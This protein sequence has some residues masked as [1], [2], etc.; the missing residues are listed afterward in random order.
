MD[1]RILR[2]GELNRYVNGLLQ[3]D[4]LLRSLRIRGEIS[5]FKAYPSGHWYFTLK[6]ESSAVSCVMWR[7]NAQRMSFR[8]KNGDRVILHGCARLYEVTGGFQLQADSMRLDG[9]GDLYQQF[10]QLK[11]RLRAEGLFDQARKRPLPARPRRIA[12]ITSAAGAVLHDIRHVSAARDPGIPLVLLPVP[13]QGAG[14]GREL[15]EA[16][17]LAPSLPLVDV[18]IIGRGGGSMEDLWCFNDEELARA[19]AACPVPV[20]SA[21]GHETDFT[22]CDFVSDVR[23]ATPSNAA[24]LA[25]PDR[26][27]VL[28]ALRS[29]RRRFDH[30]ASNSLTEKSLALTELRSR[31]GACSPLLKVTGLRS[32]TEALRLRLDHLI[33]SLLKE[34]EPRLSMAS[35]RLENATDAALDRKKRQLAELRVRLEAVS[36]NRILE[37]GYALVTGPEGVVSS[38]ANAP[39]RM[40]LRFHDGRVAVLREKENDHGSKEEAHL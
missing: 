40:I 8:P 27:E 25:V 21:V 13:V 26:S 22:I 11:E 1:E 15:A 2:V 23:A 7:S 39:E 17:R 29:M 6:D 12:V 31:M 19:I 16:I 32:R 34:R 14:A 9:V 18:I 36:P 28:S 10:E 20:I 24:E 35:I 37:R 33:N 4:W 5:G 30:A 38:A 3:D